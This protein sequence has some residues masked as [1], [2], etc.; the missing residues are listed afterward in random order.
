MTW[1]FPFWCFLSVG[2]HYICLVLSSDGEKYNWFSTN[3]YFSFSH[4]YKSYAPSDSS[5][6]NTL[7]SSPQ[8]VPE[9]LSLQDLGLRQEVCPWMFLHWDFYTFLIFRQKPVYITMYMHFYAYIH[10]YKYKYISH[11]NKELIFSEKLN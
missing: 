4:V 1:K 10:T 11:F 3:D 5:F 7:S 2:I 8:P 6:C 9:G